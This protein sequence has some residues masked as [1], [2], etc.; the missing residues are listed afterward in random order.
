[1]SFDTQILL[2]LWS[3]LLTIF[4]AGMGWLVN[5]IFKLIDDLRKEDNLIREHTS[6]TYIRRDDFKDVV[7]DL[8]DTLH[9]IET[10]LDQKV[11]K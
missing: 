1:M 2:T 8:T 10:K 11:D 3:G 7:R 9:R 4:G 6:S 5:R